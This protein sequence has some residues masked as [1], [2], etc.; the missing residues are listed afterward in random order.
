MARMCSTERM[1]AF[2]SSASLKR[3]LPLRLRP[4]LPQTERNPDGRAAKVNAAGG[5]NELH[6]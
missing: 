2:S 5:G 4:V 6:I 1:R 3:R